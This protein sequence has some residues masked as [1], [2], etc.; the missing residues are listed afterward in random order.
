[1]HK[2]VI[3]EMFLRLK[4]IL[5]LPYHHIEIISYYILFW[6]LSSDLAYGFD[7]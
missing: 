7:I 1:M 2:L 3:S 6:F 4:T 5:T